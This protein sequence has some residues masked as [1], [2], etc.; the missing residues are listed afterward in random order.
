MN[1]ARLILP[2]LRWRPETGFA[3]EQA[4]IESTLRLGV[5]GYIVFG[6]PGATAD[7]VRMLTADVR[8]QAGRP[9][10]V[11]SDLERGAGQQAQGLAEFP[12]PRA[13][14]TLGKDAVRGAA[15]RTA[16]DAA[17]VGINWVLA[18]DA[19]LDLNPDNPIV[20]TRSF[21]EDPATVAAYVAEWVRGCQDTGSL[22]CVKH[23]PGHGRTAT[24][25]HAGVPVVNATADELHRVDETPFRAGIDA[26]VASV[27]T[28]HIAFPN[29]DPSGAPATFSAAILDRLHTSLGFGGLV[30]TDALIMEGAKSG[31]GEGESAVDAIRAGCDLL[32]Y[33]N[34]PAAVKAALDAAIESGALSRERLGDALRRYEAAL[35]RA[36]RPR[37]ESPLPAADP[38]EYA[39]RLLSAG[40]IRGEAPRLEWPISLRVIDDD[41][42]GAYPP[43]PNDYV[44]RAI[45]ARGHAAGTGGARVILAFAEP[46]ASKGRAG[47]GAESRRILEQEA[48]G[49]AL[50]VLFAHP[51][52]LAEIPG[53]AP[54]L[55][56]WHRQ[57]LMQEAVG[58]WL[59]GGGG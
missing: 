10:L 5:G 41:L 39:D 20:Q 40:M 54:V 38:D 15:R 53:N 27:M 6:V 13:L 16:T 24:D 50:V 49:A 4:A 11:A 17:S 43:G 23:F 33:P 58:R 2:A 28:A 26:G 56:A 7:Q 59:V 30:V 21:G 48:P 29:L 18:P 1:S 3:H 12:P 36:N 8:R 45:A 14:A 9:L 57:R 47:F 34:D 46:R 25:S 37:T 42:G 35:E 51:R 52:L 22:A 55:L 44:E 19:D 32:C 31:R